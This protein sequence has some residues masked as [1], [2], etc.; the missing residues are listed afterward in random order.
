MSA[1]IPFLDG[2]NDFLLRLHECDAPRDSLWPGSKLDSDAG[3]HLDLDRMRR[4]GFAGGFFA[5]YV[6]SPA[7]GGS[8]DL[9]AMMEAMLTPPYAVPLPDLMDHRAA[10]PV[11][12]AMA[13]TLHWTARE[14]PEDFRLCRSASDVRSAMEAGAVAGIMHLEG[15]EAIGP[16]LDALWLFHEMGL[17][18]LGPVWS[19]PTIFGHG[20]PLAVP[21]DPDQGAGLTGYG[22][23]LVRLCAEL[24]IMVDLS[25]LNAA[26]VRD[27]AALTDAPLVAT[28][29]NA[30]ALTPSARN[31]TDDQLA[32]IRERDGMVG[33][34]F[35]TV[36]LNP[37]GSA[38]QDCGWDPVLRHLDYL[39]EA[40][41]EDRVGLG[42]D[43]D[44][45]RTPD[46]IGDVTGVPALFDRLHLH[47]YDDGLLAKLA[48]E[49]WLR[50]IEGT[51][52]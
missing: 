29:S 19:R 23:D 34:N 38:R 15:A 21:M 11:A 8:A 41:G 31:L 45:C 50:T 35:A 17:R 22:K 46:V 37:D 4:G 40:L 18:S 13:G 3:G 1:P 28:H 20:V 9:E 24:G 42:S 5:I 39:I 43:F 12:L 16:D 2:H 49:N 52:G 14:T 33:L 30:H 32:L 6:P 36:F 47:G 27:V 7:T 10:Q 51:I 25:H 48:R 44:G 26:G